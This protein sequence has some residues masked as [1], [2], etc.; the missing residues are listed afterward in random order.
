[1]SWLG[2]GSGM[3]AL[4]QSQDKHPDTP[5]N[6]HV[7]RVYP[8]LPAP[9]RPPI[10]RLGP[11]PGGSSGLFMTKATISVNLRVESTSYSAMASPRAYSQPA[12]RR[13]RHHAIIR[14]GPQEIE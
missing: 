12:L 2:N 14:A 11:S 8:Q 7:A 9:P 4:E 5:P 3:V 6:P 13:L 1:M 10:P